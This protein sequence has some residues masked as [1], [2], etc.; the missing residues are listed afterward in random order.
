MVV[1]LPGGGVAKRQPA[2]TALLLS[3]GNN[4]NLIPLVMD[5]R[6]LSTKFEEFIYSVVLLKHVGGVSFRSQFL[7]M[8]HF[9]HNQGN[10]QN[11]EI[12]ASCEYAAP[13]HRSLLLPA[14]DILI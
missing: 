6:E 11:S 14:A 12:L 9:C 2:G 5:L 1:Q 13:G 8:D 7:V 10:L 3:P 4:N